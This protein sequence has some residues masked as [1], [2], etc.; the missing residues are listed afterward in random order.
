MSLAGSDISSS[1]PGDPSRLRVRFFV[2]GNTEALAVRSIL[3]AAWGDHI[4]SDPD[5][6][7]AAQLH[8][9]IIDVVAQHEL[10]ES[11][12][13]LATPMIEVS[14][15]GAEGESLGTRRFVGGMANSDAVRGAV[16]T[17]AASLGFVQDVS[18]KV[19]LPRRK[20]DG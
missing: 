9:A 18:G 20:S 3:F 12:R 6:A 19:Y 4:S 1:V 5:T 13:V 8:L 10:A 7:S 15:Q 11:A 17:A 16:N 14:V 2:G